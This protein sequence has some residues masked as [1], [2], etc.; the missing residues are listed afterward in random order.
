M[1][2]FNHSFCASG[3]GSTVCD[4][5]ARESAAPAV[6]Q[7]KRAPRKSHPTDA[8]ARGAS[9]FRLTSHAP[10]SK[11][12]PCHKNLVDDGPNVGFVVSCVGR[13]SFLMSFCVFRASGRLR[14]PIP[15][16]LAVVRY[17]CCRS[18]L[19]GFAAC[20]LG[21][22]RSFGLKHVRVRIGSAP[23]LRRTH[24]RV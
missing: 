3:N 16:F 10:S 23:V 22:V 17:L 18:R 11:W 4:S 8:R 13:R 12:E 7:S 6:R 5:M 21:T 20:T 24:G 1:R 15:R 14:A 2:P 19:R 9:H